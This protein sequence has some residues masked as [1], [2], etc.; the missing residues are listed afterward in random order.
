[1]RQALERIKSLPGVVSAGAVQDL[2]L[3][4]N[5]MSF[6]FSVVGRREAPGASR[7]EAAYR[8][9]TEDY[10]HTMG[11]PLLALRP[12]TA[13][14]NL[15]ATPVGIINRTMA[16]RHWPGEDPLGKRLRFG[17]P[18]DPAYTIVGVVGDV[19][20]LGLAEDE[21]AAIYQPHA[22]KR[23]AWL[24]WMTIVAR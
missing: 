24:R 19:R 3:G 12:F 7:P 14:D 16:R 18:D 2:P 21:I 22:Q 4:Q 15:Q 13:G 8:A 11:I 17:E 20:H 9:V 6:P 5:A 23:F 1:F 10:F